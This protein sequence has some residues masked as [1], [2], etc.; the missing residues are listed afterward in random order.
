MAYTNFQN[1]TQQEYKT[2]IYS[3]N[4]YQRLR[5][6]VNNVEIPNMDDYCEEISVSGRIFPNGS[7]TF[8]INDLISK[9]VEIVVRDLTP[10][11]FDGEIKFSIGTL[12]DEE[13]GIYEDVPMGIFNIQEKPTTDYDKTTITLRD[14]SVKLDVPYNAQPL[15]EAGGGSATLKQIHDD[16]CV[17]CG[18]TSKITS[19]PNQSKLI[20]IYDNTINARIYINYIAGQAGAIPIIDR[21]GELNFIYL[22]NLTTHKIPLD[23]LENYELGKPYQISKVIF[24]SGII[25]YEAGTDTNDIMYLDSANVYIDNQQ[26]IN[27]IYNI[28]NGFKVD[29]VT[30]GKVLGNP[31]IDPYDL[32]QVYGYYDENDEFVAD[33]ETIVFTTFANN[34]YRYT[35]V[36]TH[37]FE[38]TISEEKRETNVSLSSTETYKKEVKTSIDN[39]KGELELSVKENE[40]ISKINLA[41][42]NGQGIIRVVGNQFILE[43]DNASIDEYGNAVFNNA[44]LR[45]GNLDL[46]DN[47]TKEGSSIKIH[48]KIDVLSMITLN[49]DLSGKQMFF[50]FFNVLDYNTTMPSE[51]KSLLKA[52]NQND[53][54][55]WL[56]IGIDYR[57]NT[58]QQTYEYNFWYTIKNGDELIEKHYFYKI[59]KDYVNQRFVAYFREPLLDLTNYA[60]GIV[61][62]KNID[63]D[64]TAIMNNIYLTEEVDKINNISG[65]G[66]ETDI[67]PRKDYD[68]N[69][70]TYIQDKISQGVAFTDNDIA[71]Y[72][73]NNDGIID[74]EDILE[75]AYM[76]RLGVYSNYPARFKLN[77]Q[78]AKDNISIFNND[79]SQG[80]TQ[81][82]VRARYYYNEQSLTLPPEISFYDTYNNVVKLLIDPWGIYTGNDNLLEDFYYTKNDQDTF[83]GIVATGHV[84]GSTASLAF[85][86]TTP[87]NMKKISS[88]S[89]ISGSLTIR[90]TGGTYMENSGSSPYFPMVSNSYTYTVSKINN[91]TLTIGIVKKNGTFSSVTNNT[92][93]AVYLRNVVLKFS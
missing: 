81:D 53:V 22:N 68:F 56:E 44:T 31:A 39:I 36:S 85:T 34:M 84:T 26:Q 57:H 71:I 8:N 52:E 33:E 3:G 88:V 18:I 42:V 23:V 61:T 47:G 90:T 49:E 78:T 37:T 89:I 4:A 86:I 54:N 11:L 38:T 92:P 91:N 14:N 58:V 60:V 12:V 80:F 77:V 16:I 10:S 51:N 25:K 46:E 48:S 87:K 20:G 2:I 30:T 6:W 9:E 32:I 76:I 43:S 13:N 93:V 35:G 82:M 5:L 64:C 24:E 41:V 45:G 67:V 17:K 69:D 70:I 63:L 1:C 28:V 79:Q 40:I 73:L 29:S 72:D 59:F 65:Y 7:N 50:N 27:S 21:D 75:I 15:I 62:E 83:N 19:F 55:K 74:D 66:I